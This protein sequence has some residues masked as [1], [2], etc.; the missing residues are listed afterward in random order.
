MTL[1]ITITQTENV[2]GWSRGVYL[3]S[4]GD[5][6]RAKLLRRGTDRET[7][8]GA[9]PRGSGIGRS[10]ASARG[11]HGQHVRPSAAHRVRVHAQYPHRNKSE[12]DDDDKINALAIQSGRACPTSDLARKLTTTTTGPLRNRTAAT[13]DIRVSPARRRTRR[14]K[15]R[16][17]RR[18]RS[19]YARFIKHDYVPIPFLLVG[20]P[21]FVFTSES[22]SYINLFGIVDVRREFAIHAFR[23]KK[24]RTIST[25]YMY[26]RQRRQAKSDQQ[27]FK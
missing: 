16:T 19:Y 6:D 4:A 8:R 3:L 26:I 2:R 20:R 22:V 18:A 5:F 11:K 13:A 25:D 1:I 27:N 10:C 14:R 15:F 9:Y 7:E 24:K 23:K 17:D 12:N 21:T